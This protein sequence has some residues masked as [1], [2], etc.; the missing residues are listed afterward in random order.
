MQALILDQA[1]IDRSLKRL[2]HQIVEREK[3]LS[4]VTVV[5][6]KRRGIPLAAQLC[7]YLEQI[8]GQ[9]VDFG[10]ID[11]QL[12]RDDLSE[13]HPD[14]QVNQNTLPKELVKNRIVILVDD[15]IYTGRTCRAALEAVIDCARPKSVR[16]ATLIDRGHRELPIRPDYIGK[17]VP[18]AKTQTV[19][20]QI[21]PFD[22]QK[23]VLMIDTSDLLELE[24]RKEK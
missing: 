21:P 4:Q 15:V 12:Y 20:V 9:P 11:I 8:G 13:L 14:P 23:Q 1:G 24:K 7:S 2:A 6:I 19:L 22:P 18:T 16:L 5:G 3:D 10:Q 17:N